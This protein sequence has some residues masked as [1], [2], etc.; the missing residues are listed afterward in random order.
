[1]VRHGAI[2]HARD[3]QRAFNYFVSAHAEIVGLQPKAPWLVTEKNVEEYEDEWENANVENR[4]YLTLHARRK[5][6]GHVPTRVQPPVSSQGIAEGIKIAAE[7]LQATTGIYNASLGAAS[8]ETSGKAIQARQREGDTGTYVYVEKYGQAI[9]HTHRIIS[10]LIPHVYDTA[11]T[12]RIVGADGTE[13]LAE[14]NQPGGLAMEGEHEGAVQ[15]DVTVDAYDIVF[16]MGPSYNSQ[17]EEAREGMLAF[18]Q[19]SPEL[20]PVMLDLVA[21]MQDWPLAD[22]VA[23]RLEIMLPPAI[24]AQRAEKNGEPPARASSRAPASL[25]QWTCRAATPSSACAMAR[26]SGARSSTTSS[27]R[28]ARTRSSTSSSTSA[29]RTARST[30][31]SRAPARRSPPTR[32]R[33]TPRGPSRRSSRNRLVPAFSA[34]SAGSKATSPPCRSRINSGTNTVVAGVFIVMS[35]TNAVANTTGT[36]YSAGDFASTKTVSRAT[37]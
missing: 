27:R 20:A 12:M 6:G 16:E 1:V 24:K 31:G 34:A 22:E 35:G 18:L 3:P 30:W 36:L 32:W 37:R 8:N 19:A 5:N 9:E 10:D 13:E 4:P 14:I 7:N 11:R 17:R 28:S 26:S 33:R 29:P 2:R 25:R 21:K 15:N 23:E